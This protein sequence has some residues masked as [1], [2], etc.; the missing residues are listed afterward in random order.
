MIKNQLAV[1]RGLVA[2]LAL[3]SCELAR[4]GAPAREYQGVVEFE[5]VDLGF[6]FAGRLAG[7][8]VRRGEHVDAGWRLAAVDDALERAATRAR[9]G[10]NEAALA[11]AAVV[12]AG[13]RPEERRALEARVRAAEAQIR[14]VSESLARER[15]LLES[16][17]TPPSVVDDLAAALDRA[18]ADRD[19]LAQNLDLLQRGP[20]R[21][22]V[23][24]LASR[25]QATQALLE[26]QV[27]RE[28]RFELR[29]PLAADV[30]DTLFEPGEVVPAGVPVVS[31]ADTT[32]PFVEVFVPQ[33][34]LGAVRQ[35]ARVEVRVDSVDEALGGA[36]EA[37]ARRTEFTPR[38]LFSERERPNLVV[39][40]RV[41]IE[42]P[43]RLLHAGVP[44]RV[45]FAEAAPA[46][47]ARPQGNPP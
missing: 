24:E 2:A 43:R 1:G 14:Q 5:Q 19:A 15:K 20:R 13:S 46:A 26:A 40:V 17:A 34:E 39:R 38:Y 47:G 16:G 7:L 31:V 21:E 4:G 37:I 23:A 41:R 12:R 27:Q 3:A 32:R 10:E 11:R 9:F 18:R 8:F 36:I 25:A 29:A 33:A 28:G 45:H 44:A 30:L 22:E 6:E 42:D 35:G